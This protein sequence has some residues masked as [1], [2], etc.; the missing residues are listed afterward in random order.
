MKYQ[1]FFLLFLTLHCSLS[2]QAD[3]DKEAVKDV[4][5][6]QQKAWNN[7]D[8]DTF[9]KYY[10]KSDNLQF[11]GSNGPIYGWQSTLER[12]QKSYPNQEAMGELTFDIINIDQRSKKVMSVVGKF[13][14]S[15]TIGDL[16]GYFLLIFQKMKGNWVIVADHTS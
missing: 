9:M 15:R 4:L 7:A 13:H 14:L 16:E 10:W 6:L 8:I 11:I 1:L 3:K 12:Y 5:A 2:A